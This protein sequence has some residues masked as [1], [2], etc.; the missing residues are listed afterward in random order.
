M[1]RFLNMITGKYK[2]ADSFISAYQKLHKR[3]ASSVDE[4]DQKVV[5]E[6]ITRFHYTDIS[7][8]GGLKVINQELNETGYQIDNVILNWIEKGDDN[9]WIGKYSATLPKFTSL[10]FSKE[11]LENEAVKI[12]SFPRFENS[13]LD[14]H[15][16][17]MK[18]IFYDIKNQEL[19]IEKLDLMI[20]HLE[21]KNMNVD[22]LEKL[23]KINK[24]ELSKYK[25]LFSEE[26]SYTKIMV[27]KTLNYLALPT[28]I[29]INT[30]A[31][32][33]Y[34]RKLV[35]DGFLSHSICFRRY[36]QNKPSIIAPYFDSLG[37]Y[38][39]EEK[40]TN[41]EELQQNEGSKIAC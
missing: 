30:V 32:H 41:T 36:V 2:D 26:L 3:V 17:R 5:D 29:N 35:T 27:D 33:S 38:Y 10:P 7:L 13:D 24:C 1:K 40:V 9:E 20:K 12:L 23:I 31:T 6:E 21:S 19:K 22:K 18:N 37:L 15:V 8:T 16:P 4:Y 14:E 34:L 25:L 39:T 11:M 28:D